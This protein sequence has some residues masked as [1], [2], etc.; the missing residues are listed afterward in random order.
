[1]NQT[2]SGGGVVVDVDGDRIRTQEQ[3]LVESTLVRWQAGLVRAR[4]RAALRDLRG[5]PIRA[6]AAHAGELEQL[7]AEFE[8]LSDQGEAGAIDDGAHARFNARVLGLIRRMYGQRSPELPDGADYA[9]DRTGPADPGAGQSHNLPLQPNQLLDRESELAAAIGR[10]TSDG[11]RLLT[12]TG[13]AGV[14]KTRL[15][16]AVAAELRSRFEDGVWFVDLASIRDPELVAVAIG[17]A[18]GV[19]EGGSVPP[20]ARLQAHLGDA[21]ALLVLDNFEQVLPAATDLA[22]LLARCPGLKVLATSRARLRLRWERVL[23]VPPLAGP[24]PGA[25]LTLAAAASAPAIALF[26]ERARASAPAFALTAENLPAVAALCAH[27]DGLPLAIELAAARANV[28]TP[29]EMIRWAARRLSALRWEGRDLPARQ[30]SLRDALEWSYAL[31]GPPEQALFRRLAVFAGGW[32]L[33]AA[34]AVADAWTLGLDPAAGLAALADASLVQ[35]GEGDGA[36]P[37]F[38]MLA[39]LR[40]LAAEHLAASGE[41]EETRRRHA[42]HFAT[43]ARI[44]GPGLRGG[45][46]RGAWRQRVERERENLRAADA[47]LEDPL[48]ARAAGVGARDLIEAALAALE[49]VPSAEAAPAQPR[50]RRPEGLLSPREHE[51]LRLVAEGMTNRQIAERL[52]ISV[53]TVNYH[54]T[55]VLNKLGAENRTQAVTLASQQALI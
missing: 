27:L 55:W 3:V 42:A 23:A 13:P 21:G 45:P 47:A 37:R 44:A 33:D 19:V 22:E 15:A 26:A 46:E 20:L 17:R 29:G 32:T 2:S 54:V 4:S 24:D 31:L 40:E 9:P 49:V 30:R 14:G 18:L 10:L 12:L 5:W 35:V 16:L 34:A 6:P 7:R 25:P 36:A 11:V 43:L 38:G 50:R 52:I 53:A 1:M 39:T 48:A 41:L 51:V 28:L 8:K